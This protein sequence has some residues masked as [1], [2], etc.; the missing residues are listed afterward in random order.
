MCMVSMGIIIDTCVLLGNKKPSDFGG[1]FIDYLHGKLLF[2]YC[3]DSTSS[4]RKTFHH[5]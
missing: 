3:I 2:K 5:L 4:S 1:F